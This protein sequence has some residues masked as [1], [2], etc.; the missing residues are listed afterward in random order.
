[1]RTLLLDT[2]FEADDA[3][4]YAFTSMV[5]A[6]DYDV[7]IWDPVGTSNKYEGAY[8]GQYRGR[9]APTEAESVALLEALARRKQEF[10]D[11]LSLGRSII[12]IAS[13][14][15][16]IWVDTGKKDTS[17]TGRNQ[18]VTRIVDDVDLLDA[19]P[20]QVSTVAGRGLELSP[21][22]PT[23]ASLWRE[24]RDRWIYRCFFNEFPG[25]KLFV[26]AGTEKVVA[27]VEVSPDGG[28][29]A[30][31]PEPWTPAEDDEVDGE[32]DED[33]EPGEGSR[34]TSDAEDRDTDVA[35][36]DL[37]RFVD[38]PAQMIAWARGLSLH[39]LEPIPAWASVFKFTSE[40]QRQE[41][42]TRLE[43]SIAKLATKVESLKHEQ[44]EDD[45]WKRLSF[46]SGTSLEDQVRRAFEVL[47]FTVLEA[48][49]G[50]SDL[51]LQWETE[52]VVVEVKGLSKSAAEKN[53]AQLEKWV[54]EEMADG[55]TAKGVLVV[56]TWREKAPDQRGTDFP[57]QMVP[58]AT[59]RSHCLLTSLQLLTVARDVSDGKTDAASAARAIL[60][61]TGVFDGEASSLR[62]E[63]SAEA[64]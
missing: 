8:R 14:P 58:Y 19:I 62:R 56:N 49:R 60:S 31:L 37:E 18:K 33:D 13:P 2:A 30:L 64:S 34:G 35:E 26:V 27:T 3:D 50:R 20:G 44:A 53:A 40:I 10:T 45:R 55:V 54:A 46:S 36:D 29:L 11:F 57:D 28:V 17:G 47:G 43:R 41:E 12:V 63:A 61:T 32:D 42:L 51:R 59:A 23:A 16:K 25:E 4:R 48:Q 22:S 24:T 5:S 21:V 52:R 9:P 6:F 7:V 1:M 15:Q 38:V 39:E